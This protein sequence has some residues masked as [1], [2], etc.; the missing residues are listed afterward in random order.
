MDNKT[1]S[2]A[3]DVAKILLFGPLLFGFLSVLSG[4]TPKSPQQFYNF[5]AVYIAASLSIIM[6]VARVVELVNIHR[7]TP[8][9]GWLAKF[10][11]N[12]TFIPVIAGVFSLNLLYAGLLDWRWI[13]PL[14]LMYPA[15][16][17]LPFVN[18]KL[19]GSLHDEAYAPTSYLARVI[20]FSLLAIGPAAGVFGV[21]LSNL[22]ERAGNGV[23]GYSIIGLLFHFLFVWGEATM[24][25]QVW[26][27]RPWKKGKKR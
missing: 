24:A 14:A 13:V 22:S 26:K 17:L 3:K 6:I 19:S 25:H 8:Q 10:I 18:P 2:L 15:A 21:F 9:K 27:E 7:E 1:H 23:I 16:A 12:M 11:V 20:I 5:T 4:L